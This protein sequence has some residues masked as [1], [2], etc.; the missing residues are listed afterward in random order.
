MSNTPRN[1]N[2]S[3]DRM[4]YEREVARTLGSMETHL[5]QIEKGQESMDK[6]IDSGNVAFSKRLDKIDDRLRKVETKSA[7]LGAG[8]GFFSAVGVSLVAEWLRRNIGI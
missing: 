2:R 5:E 6:K 8:A 1:R 4:E 7:K 3:S